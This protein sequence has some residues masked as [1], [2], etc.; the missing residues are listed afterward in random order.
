MR[1][2]S[3]SI[4]AIRSQISVSYPFPLSLALTVLRSPKRA[5]QPQP[6]HDP[7][8]CLRNILNYF[9]VGQGNDAPQ[10]ADDFFIMSGE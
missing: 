8:R 6:L 7:F 1:F 5:A 2:L 4:T 9:A 3:F 10:V